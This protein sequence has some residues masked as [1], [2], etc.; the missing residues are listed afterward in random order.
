MADA[1]GMVASAANAGSA[2][3]PGSGFSEAVG[4][5]YVLAAFGGAPGEA[6]PQP[7]D[8]YEQFDVTAAAGAGTGSGRPAARRRERLA[9]L[10]E[11]VVAAVTDPRRMLLRD[12]L[13]FVLGV[14]Q[15]WS[16]AFWLGRSPATLY[17]PYTAAVL[18]LGTGAAARRGVRRA[19]GAAPTPHATHPR[20]TL[21]APLP[22]PPVRYVLY[23]SRRW[24]YYLI[25]LC[26]VANL[27]L[28]GH[29]WLAPRSAVAAKVTFAFDT[30]PL[31][32]SVLAFRNSLVLH[33]LDKVTSVFLHIAP[34]LVSW[35][36]RWHPDTARFGPPPGAPPEDVEAW[37]AGPAWA[38]VGLPLLPYVA[39]GGAYWLIIFVLC[40]RRIRARQ[41]ATLF[42]YVSDTNK[43]GAYAAIARAVPPRLRPAVYQA[44]HMCFCVATFVVA[45]ACWHS[46]ALHTVL[47]AAVGA[48]SV[49]HGANYYFTV[50]ASRYLASVAAAQAAAAAQ[51]PPERP[52]T[53]RGA[54][55]NSQHSPGSGRPRLQRPHPGPRPAGAMMEGVAK[56]ASTH[57]VVALAAEGADK[58]FAEF[59]WL[60]S[61]GA[62]L[63]SRTVVLDAAPS[64]VEELPLAEIDGAAL[65]QEG[66]IYL[67]PKRIF[68]DPMRG[69][70][71]ILVLCEVFQPA[72]PCLAPAESADPW[73]SMLPHTSNHRAACEQVMQAAARQAPVFTAHQEY[74]LAA[75]DSCASDG[76]HYMG[77]V[78]IKGA[79]GTSDKATAR[80]GREVAELHM[81]A[82]LAAGVAHGGAVPASGG[83]HAYKVGPCLGL[84]LADQL[85]VSR[86]L[87]H[88]VADWSR[89]AVS[90]EAP[91]GG[92]GGGGPKC[93]VA[94]STA[95]SRDP[96][97]GLSAVQAMMERLH[98][99][100]PPYHDDQAGPGR[101]GSGGSGSWHSASDAF[102]A[103]D[104][105]SGGASPLH[106]GGARGGGGSTGPRPGGGVLVPTS[107][108]L[109]RC[110]PILDRRAPGG[111]DPYLTTMLLAAGACGLALPRATR[112]AM[113]YATHAM[114]FAAAGGG[115]VAI[116]GAGARCGGGPA[117]SAGSEASPCSLGGLSGCSEHSGARSASMCSSSLM[118]DCGT[119]PGDSAALLLSAL[120]AL[121]GRG[122]ACGRRRGGASCC[123][124][125]CGCCRCELAS[126]ASS[127]ARGA[128]ET[129]A[130][131]LAGGE[132]FYE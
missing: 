44:L 59:I 45:W 67:Q 19:L 120:D 33:D 3:A 41:Y 79:T 27:W 130:S 56:A 7:D 73:D 82:C 109:N 78:P 86:Y 81:A 54:A 16:V 22:A 99:A 20:G 106:C 40:A 123:G 76:G 69:G 87:L 113:A 51:P 50:F 93:A 80:L 103:S 124:G 91:H 21:P 42:D 65:G 119:R 61:T 62:D 43:R 98:A 18:V 13:A 32:W 100:P 37:A 110:G 72:L 60:G 66:V 131:T 4:D 90:Y 6:F 55:P 47:L 126:D 5:L 77:T 46:F 108:L 107:T 127:P 24:H 48:A 57:E 116:P 125:G 25:D 38:L 49:W 117:A 102:M 89:A 129:L 36:L 121:D 15:L 128:H 85:S 115:A 71:H 132:M 118:S 94:L 105:A 84:D 95:A 52:A 12:K 64:S 111:C 1:D 30:G 10:R 39:W 75:T 8:D 68:A 112:A 96:L 53:E 28:L 23:R 58:V 11:R 34:A 17:K 92:G 97:S 35:T 9:A 63:K 70:S 104:G 83:G 114:H 122:G 2:G 88:R 101:A 14:V 74:C 31:A 26:Y 29:L